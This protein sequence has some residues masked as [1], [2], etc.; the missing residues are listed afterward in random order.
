MFWV[1]ASKYQVLPLDATV[2]T[3]IVAPRPNLAAGR[4]EFTWS[5][6]I[7]GTPNGDAPSILDAS[8]NFKAEVDIPQDGAEGMIVTQDGRFGGYGF[9][10]LKGK[11]V[12]L[13]NFLDLKRTRWEGADAL[14]AGKHTL[15]FDFKYDGLG[16]GTLALNN[17][18]GVGRGGTG[19]LKVDGRE[20]VRQTIQATIPLIMQWDENFDIGA[21]TGTP[22][23]DHDYQV[24]F[25]FTG[26]LNK[27][28]LKIDRPKLTPEDTKRLETTG[29]NNRSSE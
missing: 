16:I 29:R 17:T 1:E 15:E 11:P 2:A 3:R 24:P 28:T 14:S 13:Y 19:V 6:E 12:F 23:D 20:A 10:V 8:F 4:N 27:L 22:V 25:K 21:D 26:K 7:T 5:G 18:S 9:Y